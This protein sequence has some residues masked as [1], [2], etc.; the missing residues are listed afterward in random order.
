MADSDSTKG[1]SLLPIIGV[2]VLFLL[3]LLFSGIPFFNPIKISTYLVDNTWNQ[4]IVSIFGFIFNAQTW[5]MVKIMSGVFSLVFLAIIV[6]SMVR[7]R[8]IQINDK[9]FIKE[10]VD[11]YARYRELK[12]Q[13]ENPRWNHVLSLIASENESDWRLSIIEADAMLDD[14]MKEKGYFGDT[15]SERLKSAK[16]G[17]A[18]ASYRQ[19]VEAHSI[20]NKIAHEG[21]A[22][23]LSQMETRRIMA[24][25]ES[26]FKEFGVI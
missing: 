17:D 26:V 9:I 3:F 10:M 12:E 6:F 24:L 25:Y 2:L 20:R 11:K 23:A 14:L 7:I 19:A 16:E 21:V 5:Q 22:F 8:E 18:F 4:I 1:Q 13:N 15:L